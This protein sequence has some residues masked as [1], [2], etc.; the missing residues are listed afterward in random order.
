MLNSND[1]CASNNLLPFCRTTSTSSPE[2]I[3]R[4]AR[5]NWTTCKTNGYKDR[6]IQALD[7]FSITRM[8]FS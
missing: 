7:I 8:N 3:S 1:D 4:E 6:V 2:W 5:M